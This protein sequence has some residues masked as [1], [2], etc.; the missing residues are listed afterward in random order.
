MNQYLSQIKK[1]LYDK[2]GI[3]LTNYEEEAESKEYAACRFKLNDSKIISRN[4]K[5]TPTKV[6]QFVTFW[7]RKENGPIEPFH[8]SDSLDFF[9]VICQSETEF[10]HFIFPKSILIQ[11]GILSTLHKEGK[12]AFRVYPQWDNPVSKQA[13][14]SQNWQ[15]EYFFEGTRNI[16]IPIL[17]NF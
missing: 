1:E 5:I 14:R 4:A 2:Q 7:K 13:I 12:R 15:L 6:G 10:G 11:K 9:I 3:N 8:E 16:D 17:K